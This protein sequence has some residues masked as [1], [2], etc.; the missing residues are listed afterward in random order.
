MGKRKS[1]PQNKGPTI[2]ES[3]L[4]AGKKED[5]VY[6]PSRF[7]PEIFVHNEE[8]IS[9]KSKDDKLR[10]LFSDTAARLAF[11][12]VGE[13]QPIPEFVSIGLAYE[14]QLDEGAFVGALKELRGAG[15]V[16][17][18]RL[19]I[20]C[21]YGAESAQSDDIWLLTEEGREYLTRMLHNLDSD[22]ARERT[23][24][25]NGYNRLWKSLH[26]ENSDRFKEQQL[27]QKKETSEQLL[28]YDIKMMLTL[29]KG[30]Q[31]LF[32][33]T[34]ALLAQIRETVGKEN[35]DVIESMA[36]LVNLGFIGFSK[37]VA[38]SLMSKED[39]ATVVFR[40]L[41]YCGE[42]I[43]ALAKDKEARDALARDG[44]VLDSSLA[45]SFVKSARMTEAAAALQVQP[46]VR[47][48]NLMELGEN[49]A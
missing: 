45:D 20:A 39:V 31:Q 25:T 33:L 5:E 34:P 47:Q 19:T 11:M 9:W 37:Q 14:L 38:Q 4:R 13:F 32:Q 49:A 10:S 27:A 12:V 43:T 21:G 28:P 2:E 18:K 22:H 16:R 17:S 44:V 3:L 40:C 41:P 7:K 29:M 30:G 42:R 15:L 8:G 48:S 46:R 23:D 6:E 36:K 1:R 26:A 35:R 24:M